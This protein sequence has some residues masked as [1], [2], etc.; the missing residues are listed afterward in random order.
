MWRNGRRKWRE[1]KIMS[2]WVRKGEKKEVRMMK[3]N[4][5][6]QKGKL[7]YELEEKWEIKS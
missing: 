1:G 3:K 2:T 6:R 5:R 7:T 4:P